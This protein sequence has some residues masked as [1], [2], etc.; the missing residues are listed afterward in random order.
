MVV[1]IHKCNWCWV[2]ISELNESF[3]HFGFFEDEDLHNVSILTKQLVEVVM[4]DYIAKLVVDADQKYRSI[5]LG[6]HFANCGQFCNL[7]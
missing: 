4:G 7:L 5:N 2:S 6:I 3:P 1:Q